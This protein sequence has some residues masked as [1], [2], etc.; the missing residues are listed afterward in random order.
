MNKRVGGNKN[1]FKIFIT[2]NPF[3]HLQT[4]ICPFETMGRSALQAFLTF[5]KT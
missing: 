4:S 3:I 2:P 1:F 5:R